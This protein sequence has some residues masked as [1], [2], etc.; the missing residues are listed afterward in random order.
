[1]SLPLYFKFIYFQSYQQRMAFL[2][3]PCSYESIGLT[4][5]RRQRVWRLSGAN[6]KDLEEQT[7]RKA[8]RDQL[9]P[10]SLFIGAAL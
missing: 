5:K 1:M 10:T 4:V 8:S 7:N 6:H 3:G 2:E 9:I